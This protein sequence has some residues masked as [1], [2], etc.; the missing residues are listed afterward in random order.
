MKAIVE[1]NGAGETHAAQ[2]DFADQTKKKNVAYG[3]NAFDAS[4]GGYAGVGSEDLWCG[5]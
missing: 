1:Q 3:R 2:A 4:R 5:T